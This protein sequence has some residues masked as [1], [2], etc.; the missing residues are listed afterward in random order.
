MS[1]V[2]Q[3]RSMRIETRRRSIGPFSLDVSGG[4]CV[5]LEGPNGSGKTTL[6]RLALGLDRASSGT[7]CVHGRAVDPWH[8]PVGAGAVF[9][10]DG[11]L[12][13]LPGRDNLRLFGDVHGIGPH[14]IDL[15]LDEVGLAPAADRPVR[16][17]SR[18][19]RQRLAIARARLGDP[20]LLVFDEPTVALDDDAVHWLVDLVA[21]HVR[22]GG[23]ALIASHE[24]PFL[25]ELG[26]RR[27][28]VERGRCG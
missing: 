17:Y 4:E 5:A 9:E 7:S 20:T 13:W 25:D 12:P 24:A 14:G 3:V 15:L 6:L 27:V 2:V 8:P 21:D 16:Q 11:W 26:A 19:M 18:G 28:A 22:R 10:A 23:A 1:A